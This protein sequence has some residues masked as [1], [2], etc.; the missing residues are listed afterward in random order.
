M[1]DSSNKPPPPTQ[2]TENTNTGF[3]N[4]FSTQAIKMENKFD[5]FKGLPSKCLQNKYFL[6][7]GLPVTS[8]DEEPVVGRA[9]GQPWAEEDDL[10]ED[11]LGDSDEEDPF[12]NQ[13]W[14]DFNIKQIHV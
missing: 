9:G 4:A 13:N 8:F 6:L 10:I 14:T 3:S 5:S 12:K 1:K 2:A 11:D 7:Q